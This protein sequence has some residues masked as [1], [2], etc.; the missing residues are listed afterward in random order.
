MKEMWIILQSIAYIFM[1]EDESELCFFFLLNQ[2]WQLSRDTPIISMKAT[3][4]YHMLPS[5]SFLA[6]RLLF[7]ST[8][9]VETVR[10]Y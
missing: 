5:Y 1:I 2:W 9:T 3:D 7:I 8:N 6:F 10:G 4:E